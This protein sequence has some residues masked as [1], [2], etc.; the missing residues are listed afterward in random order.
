MLVYL[1]NSDILQWKIVTFTDSSLSRTN[2][3]ILFKKL[4]KNNTQNSIISPFK[5]IYIKYKKDRTPKNV[6]DRDDNKKQTTQIH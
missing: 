2:F 3:T 5:N 6:Y 4:T 1:D